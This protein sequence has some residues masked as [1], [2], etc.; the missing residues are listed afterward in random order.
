MTEFPSGYPL[1]AVEALRRLPFDRNTDDFHFDTEIIIQL[2]RGG[3]RIAELPIPTY[4]GEE[5]CHVNG[6]KYAWHVVKATL[7]AR[8]QDLG[9]FYERKFDVSARTANNPLYQSKLEFDSPH[10]MTLARVRPGSVVADI[11]CA[12]GYI[13]H[14]LAERGCRV[15]GVDQFPMAH[16]PALE[17]FVQADLDRSGFPLDAGG[18]DYILLLDII[19]HL[20]SP[21]EFLDSL[22]CS[23]TGGADVK[24]IVSTGN[25]A[26]VVTR[27]A[28]LFGGFNYGVRGILDLT[29]TR[30]FTFA[31]V[32]RLFEQVG[33]QIEEVRGIPA[34]FPFALGH[35]ILGKLA[36]AVNK[37][38]IRVSKTLF[39]Y[40]IFMVC[41]P[42]PTLAYLLAR[43]YERRGEKV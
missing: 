42:Q 41:S 2:F 38:L 5:I 11:G 33:Y 12:S 14:A 39:S 30:L 9:V 7:L 27:L 32:R 17:R 37:A 15:T 1:S 3:F 13:S 34:P 4:Y 35:G 28:L 16:D 23:R 21:E 22:R 26:F 43:A 20:R 8:A 6:I 31:T 40:Q 18:F 24:V 10:T 25:I 19:E 36:L 29:H